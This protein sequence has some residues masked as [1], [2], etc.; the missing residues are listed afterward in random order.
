MTIIQ[1]NSCIRVSLSEF[2]IILK[3]EIIIIILL[4][5][6]N[7][8]FAMAEIAIVSAR[9]SRLKHLANEGSKNAQSALVLANNPN[10][11]LSTVQVGITLIGIL[12]GAFAGETIIDP[13]SEQLSRTP[14]LD[15]YSDVIALGIVVAVITYFSLI[16]GELVP[17][18]IALHNPEN[19]ASLIARPMN[20]LSAL[21]APLISVLTA[22]ADWVL[23]ILR[24]K[25]AADEPPI[26]EEEIKMI[27]AHSAERGA[28]EK[29]EA[30]MVYS[31]LNLGDIPVK[32]I[33]IP[34]TEIIAFEKNTPISKVIKMTQKYPHSRFP[35][36]ENTIDSII[37]FIHI[38][39]IYI[40]LIS[41]NKIASV[42]DIFKNFLK[43]KGEKTLSQLKIIRKIPHVKETER[44]DDILVLLRRKR[45]HIAV[46]DDEHGGTAG[47]VALED[48]IENLVGE[49][50][51]EFDEIEKEVVSKNNPL[52][53]ST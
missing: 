51:D 50:K 26:S 6:L 31:V 39:D 9:K 34:R 7:G 12:A 18:R 5:V 48:V 30:E 4:I 25:Q 47:L 16:I 40:N 11:F 23:K 14:F 45:I 20:L 2:D 19:I 21:T 24:I 42:R 29:E 41:D 49:I 28:I 3:M 22:S 36:Y 52:N 32:K 8:I 15:P 27:L 53:T 37:G 43:L 10:R 1:F 17:K 33:M 44:I 35:V 13:L 46:A 38:K